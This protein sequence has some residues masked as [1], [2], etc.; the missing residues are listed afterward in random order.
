MTSQPDSPCIIWNGPTRKG[1]GKAPGGHLAHR[2]TYQEAR[3]EIPQGLELDH[4]CRT[5]LCVNPD[6][7]E[8]VTRAENMRRR[9]EDYT[10]CVNGH[11]FTVANTYIRP[12]GYRDCRT[13]IRER[14]A[15]YKQKRRTSDD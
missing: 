3:G 15:R 1:Y 8:P 4:L 12:T 6:H 10:R 11:E 14:V 5:P 9:Y 13:C 7:L 2:A